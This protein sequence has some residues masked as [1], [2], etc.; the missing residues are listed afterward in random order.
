MK[1]NI[2]VLVLVLACWIITFSARAQVAVG[3]GINLSANIAPPEIP[4][5]EQPECPVEG[6]LWTPGYWSYGDEGYFWVPGVWVAPP[7]PR[8]LWTP[9]YWG[10]LG[11]RYRWNAGYW[12]RHIGFYGG[13]NYGFG[14]GGFGF[15]GGGWR[16]NVFRYNTAVMNVNRTVVRN[17]YVNKTVIRNTTIN[18]ISYN[19]GGGIQTRA[20]DRELRY[21]R[22]NH[23]Q[24]TKE[25]FAHQQTAAHD[26]SQ[27]SK[28]NGGRPS[29]TAMNTV[30]G[31]RFNQQGRIAN[32][33]SNGSLTPRETKNLENRSH[34]INNTI[35]Q[36]RI[37]NGGTLTG[38]D[39]QNIKARQEN[40]N[41][42]IYK[43]KHNNDNQH[44][45]GG[46]AGRRQHNQQQRIA[47]GIDNGSINANQAA[48]DER[49]QQRIRQN[50]QSD[51]RANGGR[52]NDAQRRQ[53]NRQ[54]NNAG[55]H[56]RGEKA[57]P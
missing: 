9:G 27:F 40:L 56:I 13:V 17:T 22:E 48:R 46:V 14:Y 44:F 19:G 43:D 39:R 3:V 35:R 2:K 15:V 4:V 55:R 12:G 8:F 21:T 57:K 11:G 38:K 30:N 32:G 45:G 34:N 37:D 33:V 52:M 49:R 5:Y 31:R 50:I 51:R 53:I 20:S 18:R 10:F 41:Q 47:R 54:Q 42:S 1:K 25:Q 16:G 29:T 28:N 6:Y 36:D 23:V 7:R 24:A 26:P